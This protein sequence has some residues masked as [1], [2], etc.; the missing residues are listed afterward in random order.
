MSAPVSRTAIV[1]AP[2]ARKTESGTASSCAAVNCHSHASVF[3]KA[4]CKAGSAAS[5][6]LATDSTKRM[7]GSLDIYA[8]ESGARRTFAIRRAGTRRTTVAS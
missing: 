5:T 4:V 3:P 8:L 2:A 7:P 1:T 6:R